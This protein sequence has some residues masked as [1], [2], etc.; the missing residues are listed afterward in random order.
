MAHELSVSVGREPNVFIVSTV[1]KGK[2]ISPKEAAKRF[3]QGKL[4]ALEGPFP[5]I[6]AAD[7]ASKIR[8]KNYKGKSLEP[9]KDRNDVDLLPTR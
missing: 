9:K 6:S 1:I 8:S 5:T 4:K 3:E 7:E 2:K